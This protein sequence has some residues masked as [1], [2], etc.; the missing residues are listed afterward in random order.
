MIRLRFILHLE[1]VRFLRKVKKKRIFL[2]IVLQNS[3]E[4]VT[5][6]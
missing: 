4:L 5:L 1:K 3:L 6:T 2:L